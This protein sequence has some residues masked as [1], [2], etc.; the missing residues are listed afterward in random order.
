MSLL[1]RTA[2]FTLYAIYALD[3]MGLVFVYV[4]I[5][6]LII[7]PESPMVASTLSLSSRN[8]VVGLLVATYP[9]AQFF[10]A[11][12][13]G[14]LSDRFGRRKILLVST[15]GTALMFCLSGLSILV[16]SMTLLFISRLLSGIFCWKPNHCSSKHGRRDT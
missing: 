15:L 8:L 12:T 3:L 11:P 10:A 6:P 2:I 14:D 1:S 7:A 4:I 5:P 16:R 13:L 9:F